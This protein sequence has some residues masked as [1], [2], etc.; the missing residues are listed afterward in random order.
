MW[1]FLS[2]AILCVFAT[3]GFV[4]F[5]KTLI[6]K[7]YKPKNEHAYLILKY[8]KECEDIEYT[9]RSWQKHSQW[10]GKSAPDSIIILEDNLSK[11]QK[12]ICRLLENESEFIKII[13][14]SELYEL[15]K[16]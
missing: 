5:L 9:V 8:T 16:K 3:F 11:E 10:L 2:A 14:T 15:I 6:I 13:K 1:E 12:E 7:I 4:A